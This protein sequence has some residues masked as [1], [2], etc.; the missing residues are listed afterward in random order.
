LDYASVLSTPDPLSLPTRTVARDL[1]IQVAYFGNREFGFRRQ[2]P[3]VLSR[4]PEVILGGRIPFFGP[5][6][7]DSNEEGRQAL[8]RPRVFV[9]GTLGMGRYSELRLREN[10]ARTATSRTETSLGFGTRPLLLGDR[11]LVA[12]QATRY[13][14]RYGL[15]NAL[16]THTFGY[17]EFGAAMDVIA[18]Y[19]TSFGMAYTG[20]KTRGASP[21]LFDQVDANSEGQVRGQVSLRGGR[22]VLGTALRFD[23]VERKLFD[24]EVAAAFR[25]GIVETRLSFRQLN[26][27]FGFSIGIIGITTPP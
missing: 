5:V 25:R 6:P 18:G 10:A 26:S 3:L 23:V 4:L 20:R 15:K 27:Q 11:V 19:R 7:P 2:G 16:N 9:N 8:R 14:Y 17:D 24:A 13:E 1:H 22:L 21:F 12:G